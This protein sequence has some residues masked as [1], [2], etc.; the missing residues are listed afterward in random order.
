MDYRRKGLEK[1]SGL[2]SNTDYMD[3]DYAVF[4]VFALTIISIYIHINI[5][6]YI[7]ISISMSVFRNCSFNFSTIDEVTFLKYIKDLSNNKTPGY[8]GIQSTFVKMSGSTLCSSHCSIFNECVINNYFPEDMKYSEISPVFKKNDNLM[9]QSYRSVNLLTVFSKL[10]ERIMSD[11]IMSYFKNILSPHLSA[12]R[13]GYSCQHVII[14]LTEFWRESLDQNEYV[15]TISTDLSKAFD[16][17]PHGL[18][19]AKLQ[20][21]GFSFSAFIF[22]MSY[23]CDRKQRV[24]IS[25]AKSKWSCI[26]RGV[27]QGSVLGPLLFNI[28]I[29]D[30][31]YVGLSSRIANYADENNLYN[32]CKCLISL[33]RSLSDDAER[34]ISW[35]GSNYPMSH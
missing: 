12:Y 1:T 3:T 5:C 30:L 13:A 2:R 33:K 28:F 6:K 34:T 29:N 17:M 24:K 22:I 4:T 18:L 26:N 10:F 14:N 7:L 35:Y 15:G 23:L 20:A 27:P 9:K 16:K 11:Q 8:D 25:G 19:I 32:A 31:F 21:Y